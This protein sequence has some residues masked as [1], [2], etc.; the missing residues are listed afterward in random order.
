MKIRDAIDASPNDPTFILVEVK[1]T[2]RLN[3][4]S[5]LAELMGQL[6]SQMIRR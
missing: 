4:S 6:K 5:S 1:R 3:D 2:S